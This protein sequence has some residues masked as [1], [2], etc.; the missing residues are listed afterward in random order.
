MRFLVG[1]TKLEIGG[2]ASVT[3]GEGSTVRAFLDAYRAAFETFDAAAVA[4]L[5]HY[6][7][8]S[9]GGAEVTVAVIPTRDAWMPQ[10]ERLVAAYRAI[11]V[12]SAEARAVDVAEITT[13]LAPAVV[14]WSL[15]DEEGRPIYDFDASYT[16]A[17]LGEGMRITAIAHNE[18]P[19]LRAAIERQ[20]LT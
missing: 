1:S 4:D 6:P 15:F 14:H 16:L 7:A 3:S 13:R 20:R 12:R 11:G 8:R 5:F 19:C 9:Q 2:T 17:D 18:T 10:L